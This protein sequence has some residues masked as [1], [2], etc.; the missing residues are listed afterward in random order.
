MNR[1]P[2]L[3]YSK[4]C[5]HCAEVLNKIRMAP[6]AFSSS[7]EYIIIDG[8]RNLPSFLKEVPTLVVPTHPQPI[9]G[10]AVF[11]WIDTQVRMSAQQQRAAPTQQSQSQ[12]QLSNTN[13]KKV[14]GAIL[15]HM[16][17][18][19]FYNAME[20]SGFGDNYLS[21]EDESGGQEHCF[22][23]IDDKGNKQVQCVPAN[24][25][26]P[27]YNPNQF[28]QQSPQQQVPDWLKPL[29]VGRNNEQKSVPSNPN[30]NA[31]ASM[32]MSQQNNIRL[33][34]EARGLP[35]MMN[36]QDPQRAGMNETSK[37]NDMDYE[38][39]ASMRDNDPRIMPPT[40][41]I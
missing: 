17:G 34:Q 22:V 4:K 32:T 20:M 11:M 26:T 39:Y 7:F 28:N 5:P 27:S 38:K 29:T 2:T 24:S 12:P 14:E 3:F 6:A 15:N 41:R 8:N 16:D 13:Q 35:P 33:Q 40:Q 19:S 9:T 36:F 23:F 37:L 18:L 30:Q 10:D 21:L 31:A 1:K 25:N